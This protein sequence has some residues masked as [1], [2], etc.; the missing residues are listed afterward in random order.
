MPDTPLAQKHAKDVAQLWQFTEDAA[1]K[2]KLYRK[3]LRSKQEL[4]KSLS[5]VV[6][7]G[8]HTV[9]HQGYK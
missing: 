4:E 9:L 1:E 8:N 7:V 2:N 3:A 5:K 6:P